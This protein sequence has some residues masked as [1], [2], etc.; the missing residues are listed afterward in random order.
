MH[1][2]MNHWVHDYETISNCFV[3]CFMHYSND[4]EKVFVIHELRDDFDELVSFLE[5][6]KDNKEWHIS[7]NGLAF[8]SQI[9]HYILD[10]KSLLSSLGSYGRA[11]TLY[12]YAQSVIDKKR[13]NAYLDYPEW[14]MSIQQIDVFKLNHW[15]NPAKSSSLKWIQYTMDWD[16]IIEMPI[17]HTATIN[18]LEEIEQ[19]IY[20]C[21]NDV[22]STKNIM[23][24]SKDQIKLR[25][26]LTET[27]DINLYSASEPRISKELFMYFLTKKLGVDKNE[28]KNLR[29]KREVINLDECILP[30]ISFELPVFQDLLSYFK[31]KKVIETKNAIEYKIEHKG[32]ETYYGLGGIHGATNPGV[33]KAEN[34][35]IIMTSDVTSYYPNLAIRNKFAPAHL[36]IEE[37]LEQYEWFFDERKLIPK[38]D[39][40]NYVYKIILNST[41]GLSN[42]ENSFLYDPKMTMQITVNG[43]LLLSKLYEMLSLGIPH[44]IPLMQ[45]TDGL[46]M[47]IREEDKEKYLE[48]CAEWEK[49]T[50]LQLEHDQYSKLILRDVNN[51]IAVYKN[52]KTKCKGFFEYDN[53]A[54]HK[55]K[56][57]LV[58]KKAV[59]E[60]FVNNIMPEHYIKTNTN[61]YDFC[62][63]VKAKGDW[64]IYDYNFEHDIPEKYKSFTHEQKIEH[65]KKN[66]WEQSWSDDN[67]VKSSATNKEANT[68]IT[69]EH[70]FRYT[71]GQESTFRKVQLQK[72]NRYYISKK[73]CKMVKI[74]D[75]DQ[76]SIQVESGK[77]LQKVCN[78]IST[79]DFDKADINYDY[80]LEKIYKEIDNIEAR[81]K[82]D[83]QLTLF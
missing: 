33:Y 8:D 17:H 24:L 83:M 14:R 19:I 73:G 1:Y 68:G 80:Y 15:D 75:K 22:R 37:F 30:Y 12:E 40:R 71:V 26:Q 11:S 77:W 44:S 20:Y 53:L 23:L 50:M 34:G 70:A 3:A 52:G 42:D 7:F 78:N 66:G 4:E 69:T 51:Y 61:I 55:N 63:G 43:Q 47:M 5:K 2:T 45:N 82:D 27:Y 67:W 31:N 41:Y 21:R 79:V 49:M 38:S 16:D 32:V 35:W 18:T 76:R 62:A 48:I 6:N 65:L 10:K 64:S 56:S 54:L 59:Y 60:Y 74:N 72:V 46:E 39:I 28:I 36:P 13:V 29:T 9:T 25:K 81:R 57:F 58:I